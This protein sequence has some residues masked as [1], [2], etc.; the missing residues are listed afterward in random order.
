MISMLVTLCYGFKNY[1]KLGELRNTR[2]LFSPNSRG[3]I[4]KSK[5]L[6]VYEPSEGSTKNLS[7]A[8]CL[9]LMDPSN[10]WHALACRYATGRSGPSLPFL[11]LLLLWCL[12]VCPVLITTLLIG[13]KVYCNLELLLLH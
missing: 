7:F 4:S 2:N 5:V 13:L 11:W 9:L 3:Q 1:H 10:H 12:S 6:T 8:R